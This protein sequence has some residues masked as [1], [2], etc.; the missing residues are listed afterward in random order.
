MMAIMTAPGTVSILIP[1]MMRF[2]FRPMTEFHENNVVSMSGGKDSTAM[3]EL[4]KE[5]GE[6]IHSVVYCDMGPWEFPAMHDHIKAVEQS[7]GIPIVRV[8]P[9]W[10]PV[11]QLIESP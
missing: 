1:M 7:T 3:L 10:D 6:P 11:Y 4:M 8:K 5:H 9:R 2:S